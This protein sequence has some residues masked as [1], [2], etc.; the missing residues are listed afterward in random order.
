MTGGTAMITVVTVTNRD[1]LIENV[2]TNFEHQTKA[3]KEMIVVLNHSTMDVG[4]WKKRASLHHNIRVYVHHESATLG[5]CL[6]LAASEA[7]YSVIS[8][9]D[10]DDFYGPFYL[11]EV[12]S[13]FKETDADVVGKA[14]I[15]TYFEEDELLSLFQP[16]QENMEVSAADFPTQRCLTGATLSFRKEVSEKIPFASLN[17]GEDVD[18]QKRCLGSGMRLW[19]C[20]K[21]NYV[22]I[23]YSD[24]TH[25]SSMHGTAVLKRVSQPIGYHIDY[26]NFVN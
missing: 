6:N 5:E 26:K 13:S 23:R 2:F 21:K 22:H 9:F 8:K 11:T 3:E 12:E 18:F 17:I 25:H 15:Y 7:S 14:A 16:G 10:D 1:H 24:Q 20:S 4:E 19:S